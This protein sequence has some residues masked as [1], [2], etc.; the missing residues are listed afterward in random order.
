VL[1]AFEKRFASVATA[2]AMLA[3]FYSAKQ[4]TDE[5]VNSWG[6]RLESWLASPQ[7]DYLDNEQKHQMLRERFWRGLKSDM[8]RNALRH[9]FD[10]DCSY[11]DLLMVA[12]AIELESCPQKQSNSSKPTKT[13]MSAQA[14]KPDTLLE[15]VEDILSRLT[16][17]EARF[18]AQKD[19]RTPA[20]GRGQGRGRGYGGRG[21]GGRG[22]G[23]GQGQ[24]QVARTDSTDAKQA[25]ALPSTSGTSTYHKITCYKCG[26]EGHMRN[27]CPLN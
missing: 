22:R 12:R 4:K 18:P 1:N 23:R 21:R 11:D 8:H 3:T 9:K 7:L 17:L 14:K 13:A 15:K 25:S 24:Q 16:A 10:G 20:K 19:T 5:S 26:K 2:E 6:C 27:E